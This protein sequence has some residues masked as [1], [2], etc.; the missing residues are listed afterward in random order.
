MTSD[1]LSQTDSNDRT[2][3]VNTAIAAV[4]FLCYF[5]TSYRIGENAQTI[6]VLALILILVARPSCTI[7]P[8]PWLVVLGTLFYSLLKRPL[9]VPNHHYMMTYLS[10]ALVLTFTTPQEKQTSI[11]ACN[12][13]WMLVVLMGF[14]TVQKLLS[15]T[16]LDS[17]YLGYEL[18]RGGFCDPVLHLFENV[19]EISTENDRLIEEFRSQSPEQGASVQ[20]SPPVQNLTTVARVFAISIL[21]I[22]LWLCVGFLAFPGWLLS[23]LSLLAF[24]VTLG[25]LRQE[26]TFISVVSAMGMM[27]CGES[28]PV[29]RYTYAGLAVFTAAAVL[30]TLN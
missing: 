3:V 27:A 5:F 21:A 29:I 30:K 14:A 6:G 10:L 9:D 8:W 11:I 12:V 7:S 26:F 24:I 22:E 28:R 19:A 4:V 2:L 18:V 1:S 25:V 23:H 16:F 13:R 17:S 15:P 20:L